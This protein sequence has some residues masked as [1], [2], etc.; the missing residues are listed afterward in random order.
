MRLELKII[1]KLVREEKECTIHALSLELSEP[2]SLLHR[3][4]QELSEEGVLS[5]KTAG[6]ATLCAINLKNSKARAL[7]HLTEV[8][9]AQAF[10]EKNREVRL[11]LASFVERAKNDYKNS[12]SFIVLFGS[13]AQEQASKESDIDLF[14]LTRKKSDLAGISRELNA[15]YGL[16]INPL[17]LTPK[18]FESEREKELIKTILKTHIVLYGF[19]SFLEKMW[20]L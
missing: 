2:Y 20:P 19:E 11:L 14:I 3:K 18:E 1:E 5:K 8:N 13:W 12:L 17:Q 7:L 6:K 15:Q 10:M 9:K 4:V 16:E